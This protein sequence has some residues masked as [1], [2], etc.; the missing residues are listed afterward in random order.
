MFPMLPLSTLFKLCIVLW[1]PDP[2][3]TLSS[4]E[5]NK[6]W[7]EPTSPPTGS[8]WLTNWKLWRRWWRRTG[9]VTGIWRRRCIPADEWRQ[10]IPG[11]ARFRPACQRGACAKSAGSGSLWNTEYLHHSNVYCW[12]A[13][14]RQ[15]VWISTLCTHRAIKVKGTGWVSRRGLSR[16]TLANPNQ[17]IPVCQTIKC[18]LKEMFNLKSRK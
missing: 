9:S 13:E 5:N 7:G 2:L 17:R 18:H 4:I 10:Q 1:F 3:F 15:G 12:H 14:E 6:R 11:D 8:L 16:D